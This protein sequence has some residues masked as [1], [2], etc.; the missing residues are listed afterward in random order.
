M[1]SHT[2]KERGEPNAKTITVIWATTKG[3]GR[4]IATMFSEAGAR[5]RKPRRYVE[6][7]CSSFSWFRARQADPLVALTI[8]VDRTT[9]VRCIM[10]EWLILPKGVSLVVDSE[11]NPLEIRM[12]RVGHPRSLIVVDEDH[13]AQ[14]FQAEQQEKALNVL[15]AVLGKREQ[16]PP[17]EDRG[18]SLLMRLFCGN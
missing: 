10:D 6:S 17:P 3:E 8:G 15:S 11:M 13:G 18:H 14:V 4:R 9:L 1:A 7:E 12:E 2:A 5:V 16:N